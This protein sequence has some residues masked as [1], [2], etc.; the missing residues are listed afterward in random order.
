MNNDLLLKRIQHTYTNPYWFCT[1]PGIPAFSAANGRA[2][3]A[4][5]ENMSTVKYYYISNK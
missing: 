5:L 3:A 1:N 2:D 4:A